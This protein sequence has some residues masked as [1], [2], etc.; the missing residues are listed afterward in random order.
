ML[1]FHLFADAH[2]HIN[3]GATID[4]ASIDEMSALVVSTQ[5]DDWEEVAAL[6]SPNVCVSFGVHPWF[7]NE[8][9][10][11]GRVGE[12][13]RNFL[14]AHPLAGV[15]EIGLD[16]VH[17][18]RTGDKQSARRHQLHAFNEQLR[19]AS[20]CFRHCS[21]HCVREHGA[22]FDAL[23][24]LSLNRAPRA[25]NL[26]SWSGSPDTTRALLRLEIGERIYFGVSLTVNLPLLRNF[27][28]D[29]DIGDAEQ[30]NVEIQ[31]ILESCKDTN[32]AKSAW[33]KFATRV[34]LIPAPRLLLE[35]DMCVA[36]TTVA[37]RMASMHSIA[38]AVAA[39][40]RGLEGRSPREWIAQ[41][42]KNL[43]RFCGKA[44]Q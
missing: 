5:Q 14:S 12:R 26:H 44:M 38:C 11:V 17:A 9:V 4:G 22:L 10:F 7:A 3:S 41:S 2:C 27:L 25:L 6:A 24:S 40:R 23:G 1:P 21:I 18:Q 29:E 13:L 8:R 19:I 30:A 39:S 37:E 42:K 31:R 35:S 15:G 36:S 33:S 20:E 32:R 28:L 34:A 43:G 16:K